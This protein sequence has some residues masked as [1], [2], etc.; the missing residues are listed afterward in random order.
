MSTK[1]TTTR[2]YLDRIEDDVAVVLPEDDADGTQ[3]QHVPRS[4]LPPEARDGDRLV[5][6][7]GPDGAATTYTLDREASDAAKKR[8]QD[9]MDELAQ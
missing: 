1:E 8:V 4:A 2:W 3:E 6:T 5:A 7:A 9:L